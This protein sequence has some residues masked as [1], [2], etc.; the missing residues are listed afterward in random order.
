MATFPAP[1]TTAVSQ[2]KSI[3][4]S[5]KSGWALYQGTKVA[6][7]IEP[8][9]SSP[10]I[11]SF[12]PRAEPVAITTASY[13]SFSCSNVKSLPNSRFANNLKFSSFAIFSN[14]FDTVLIFG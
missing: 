3:D 8:T 1:M 11:P 5:L 13:F 14:T 2:L 10:G 4:S 12:F 7:D 6:A 9:S